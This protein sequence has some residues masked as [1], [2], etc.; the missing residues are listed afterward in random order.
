MG[1]NLTES[2]TFKGHQVFMDAELF[3][4]KNMGRF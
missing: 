1:L 3:D 2:E 4:Q